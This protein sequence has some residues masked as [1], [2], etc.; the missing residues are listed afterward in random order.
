LRYVI[1][2][3]DMI[4][5]GDARATDRRGNGCRCRISGCWQI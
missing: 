4:F 2:A 5:F 1:Y 3:T